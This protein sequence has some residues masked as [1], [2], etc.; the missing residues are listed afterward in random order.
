MFEFKKTGIYQA[1]K[2][3]KFPLFRWQKFL[4][5]LFFCFT[6]I[7]AGIFIYGFFTQKISLSE[8]PLLTGPYL[9]FLPHHR[10]QMYSS[11]KFK[12]LE[13]IFPAKMSVRILGWLHKYIIESAYCEDLTQARIL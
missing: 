3:S 5:I 10:L 6:A 1:V 2:W 11:P 7:F 8:Q 9:R 13:I 12:A 4:Q